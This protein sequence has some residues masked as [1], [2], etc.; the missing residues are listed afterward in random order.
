MVTHLI[1][2]GMLGL[3]SFL[4]E[5]GLGRALNKSLRVFF[6]SWLV[7][8][9]I[10][11]CGEIYG[12]QTDCKEIR[13]Q[14]IA[15]EFGDPEP[16]ASGSFCFAE[17]SVGPWQIT[18]RLNGL[19]P[20][21]SYWLSLNAGSPGT[22]ENRIL[23]D[24][25]IPGW[26]AGHYFEKEGFWDFKEIK[27]DAQG[28]FEDSASL[29]LPPLRYHVKFLI[30]KSY[31]QKGGRVVL[32]TDALVF[33]IAESWTEWLRRWLAAVFIIPVGLILIWAL[34]RK[35]RTVDLGPDKTVETIADSSML[36]V[37]MNRAQDTEPDQTNK[38]KKQNIFRKIGETWTIAYNGVSIGVGDHLGL[39]YIAHLLRNP[40]KEFEAADLENVVSRQ[41]VNFS[42]IEIPEE[43]IA[44]QL[45]ENDLHTDTGREEVIDRKTIKQLNDHIEAI[46]EQLEDF[47]ENPSGNPE[48]DLK[49]QDE[50]RSERKRIQDYLK[51]GM[52]LRGAPRAISDPTRQIRDRVTKS[53]K[54][55]LEAIDEAKKQ[56]AANKGSA[57]KEC[58][59]QLVTHLSE[60]LEPIRSPFR[61]KPVHPVDWVF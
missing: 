5:I 39:H 29:P 50:L 49:K 8:G 34:A 48:E 28:K 59:G 4:R 46:N 42:S 52:G 37:Q 1:A 16:G 44:N 55:A 41:R 2:A 32:Y 33:E 15:P 53:I 51:K 35:F 24:I 30:K 38:S 13:L 20:N 23:G 60:S 18:V 25:R 27:T 45:A 7:L 9:S 40:L 14:L 58:L 10:V 3:E 57:E 43:M 11:L 22:P 61:Y 54:R 47:K 12:G 31:V 21:E 6:S 19:T 36:S 26:R 56:E 17:K